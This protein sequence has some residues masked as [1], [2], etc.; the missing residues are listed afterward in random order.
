MNPNTRTNSVRLMILL[1]LFLCLST[2]TLNA[3]DFKKFSVGPGFSINVGYFTPEGPN[4]Y[5]AD[6]LSGTTIIFGNTDIFS[7]FEGSLFLDFKTRW[8]DIAPIVGYAFAGKIE[9][10]SDESFIFTRFSPGVVANFHI[11]VGLSGKNAFFI[12]GGIQYHTI[13]FVNYEGK[14]LGFRL[15]MG[16]DM[17]FGSFNMQPILALVLADVP[18]SML[19]NSTRYDMNYDGVQIGINMSFHK[20]V[21]HRR[22]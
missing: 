11:P 10:M 7:Y 19:V 1:S 21:S 20:P 6:A 18:N 17:Q 3:Q 22:F 14:D 2:S 13:K 12:G 9:L 8:I 16:Y 15:Q 4:A 5:I